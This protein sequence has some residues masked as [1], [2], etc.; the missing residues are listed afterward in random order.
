MPHFQN[1]SIMIDTTTSGTINNKIPTIMARS[2]LGMN[3]RRMV[4]TIRYKI[5]REVM[6]CGMSANTKKKVTFRNK[7]NALVKDIKRKRIGYCT[8]L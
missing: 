6:M 4:A 5:A 1:L 7:E 8:P 2:S 3:A